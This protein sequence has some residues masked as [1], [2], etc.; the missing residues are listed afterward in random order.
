MFDLWEVFIVLWKRKKQHHKNIDAISI[1]QSS[2]WATPLA[3]LGVDRSRSIDELRWIFIKK[4]CSLMLFR[5]C[6]SNIYL[7]ASQGCSWQVLVMIKIFYIFSN[8]GITWDIS[9]NKW[10]RFR[11]PPITET[12]LFGEEGKGE[13]AWN[14][15]LHPGIFLTWLNQ[16][17]SPYDCHAFQDCNCYGSSKSLLA[18][19]YQH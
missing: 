16:D 2:T 13:K 1:H 3:G 7:K 8:V 10:L 12:Y 11:R 6:S 17:W 14:F 15:Y 9:E 19:Y 5:V 4:R 18:N